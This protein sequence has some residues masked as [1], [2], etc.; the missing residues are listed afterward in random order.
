M[1]YMQL[2]GIGT[3][4]IVLLAS[5]D[6]PPPAREAWL[7]AIGVNLFNLVGT[8]LL[9][10]AFAVGA[11]AVVSPI[12]AGFAVVT[13]GLAMTDG[14]RLGQLALVG[15]ALV[16]GGVVVVSRGQGRGE[17]STRG[18]PEALGAALALG[19]F[20][21]LIGRVT[22]QMG[23]AWPVLVGRVTG[24]LA[25]LLALLAR[26]A[27]PVRLPRGLWPAVLAATVFDTTAFLAYNGG[28]AGAYVSVVSALASIF[29]AVTVLLAWVVLRERLARAQ[30]AGVLAILL[31]V[32]LVSV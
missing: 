12:A 22:P 4:G 24:V 15:T 3:I 8:L 7:L 6:T 13:A 20:F 2:I 16:I 27:Q 21:W 5:S 31:G 23:I 19:I 1:F 17:T 18:V 11:L 10:R 32:L 14:E 25:S 30:W 28:I 9:Y 29:S 26:G